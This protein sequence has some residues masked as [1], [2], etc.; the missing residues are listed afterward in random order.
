[1]E[2]SPR[3]KISKEGMA[4]DERKWIPRWKT[5]EER[6]E[7]SHYQDFRSPSQDEYDRIDRTNLK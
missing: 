6:E 4:V 1:M 3:G 2:I 5:R 7:P